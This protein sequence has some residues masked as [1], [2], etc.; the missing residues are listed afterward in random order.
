MNDLENSKSSR[1]ITAVKLI[2]EEQQKVIGREIAMQLVK[3]VNGIDIRNDLIE[4]TGDPKVALNDLV[5]EYAKLFG[6][7]S[8]EVSKEAIKKLNPP[9]SANELP[10]NLK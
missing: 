4:I 8:V 1:Y 3:S 10:D 6:Q 7:I 9:L 2:T 5:K